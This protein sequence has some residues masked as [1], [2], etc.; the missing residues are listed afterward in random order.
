MKNLILTLVSVIVLIGGISLTVFNTK[1]DN[2]HGTHQVFVNSFKIIESTQTPSK[3]SYKDRKN[4]S[5]IEGFQMYT[6]D[7][8]SNIVTHD[9]LLSDDKGEITSY[10]VKSK[11][12][13]IETDGDFFYMTI[14]DN[15][16]YYSNTKEKIFILNVINNKN[17][18]VLSTFW[19]NKSKMSGAYSVD[20]N[21]FTGL[22]QES[23]P[24]MVFNDHK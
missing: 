19:K 4:D 21:D 13:N 20:N 16:K 8:D 6:F 5:L 7:F 23:N 3:S 9:F 14:E 1:E 18:P 17:Y 22:I 2:I 10:Q 11:I 24:D 15:S 12:T